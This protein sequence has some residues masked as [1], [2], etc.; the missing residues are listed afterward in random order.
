MADGIIDD[1]R[2]EGAQQLIEQGEG[3]RRKLIGA[4]AGL[5]SSATVEFH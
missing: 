4:V 2:L 3:P 5:T 1:A